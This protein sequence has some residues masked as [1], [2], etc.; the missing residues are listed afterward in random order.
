MNTKK[1]RFGEF[2]PSFTNTF[3]GYGGMRAEWCVDGLGDHL[4]SVRVWFSNGEHCVYIRMSQNKLNEVIR[5][6]SSMVRK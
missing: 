4:D 1:N 3:P 6:L 2:N 5:L